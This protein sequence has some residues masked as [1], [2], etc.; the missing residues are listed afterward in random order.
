MEYW[1]YGSCCVTWEVTPLSADSSI[2]SPS[3]QALTGVVGGYLHGS[4]ELGTGKLTGPP[5]FRSWRSGI[6]APACLA[7]LVQIRGADP[8][9]PLSRIRS[10]TT[11]LQLP[12]L[13]DDTSS[14]KHPLVGINAPIVSQKRPPPT[15]CLIIFYVL[16]NG[17]SCSRY[18][19]DRPKRRPSPQEFSVIFTN[20][21]STCHPSGLV[22][23]P[24]LTH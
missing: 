7:C 19:D 8:P 23:C 6:S 21:P 22:S 17:K 1:P 12:Q 9:R 14:Q 4:R 3:C 5:R 2:A 13:L 16:G 18:P 20:R 10:P 11:A 15:A 24:S